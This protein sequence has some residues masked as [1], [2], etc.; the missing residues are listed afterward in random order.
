[1]ALTTCKE[2]K[3]QISS[4]AK[5]CPQ[6]GAKKRNPLLFWL[7]VGAITYFVIVPATK[8]SLNNVIQP[9]ATNLVQ[10]AAPS[11]ADWRIRE[12]KSKMD[13]S[14]M[15]ILTKDADASIQVWLSQV[16]PTLHIRCL[17]KKIELFMIAG[18]AAQ[19]E[20]GQYNKNTVEVRVDDNKPYKELWGQSTD[21]QALYAPHPLIMAK[22]LSNAKNVLIRFTPFNV[23]PATV[24]FT[25]T[26]LG[27]LL[28]K[29]ANACK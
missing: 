10:V 8:Q 25:T 19:P 3:K 22:K 15:V 24:E 16:K 7:I 28:P 14:K 13:D 29:V 17:E 6:C 11:A 1:M 2:C 21:G 26:R 27:Q 23:P 5:R 20:F 4:N 9:R 12:D 18:T